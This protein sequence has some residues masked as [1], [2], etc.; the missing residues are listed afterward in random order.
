MYV[1]VAT[2][3]ILIYSASSSFEKEGVI[4]IGTLFILFGYLR[5]IG[6]AFFTFA[7]K[8]GEIVRQDSAVRAAE[9]INEEYE[10]LKI[11]K[12]K[13]LP[14]NWQKVEVKN[15]N[16]T[17]KENKSSKANFKSNDIHNA[18]FRFSR[19]DKIAFIGESGS[20]K[21]TVLSLLRG[22][23]FP[24]SGKVFCDGKKLES[25]IRHLN[26][27]ILL[28]P[29]DPEL[30]NATVKENI[31]MGERVGE[32]KI[33]KAM[34]VA[35]FSEVVTRLKKGLKTNV[36][37][38]GVS[39]SGGEKQRLALSR[40]LLVADK[41]DIILLDEPTSSVDSKNELAIYQKIFEE[42]KNK[43]II[44]SIH[45][46]HLLPKFDYIYQFKKGEIVLEGTFEKLLKD[47][48]FKEMWDDYNRREG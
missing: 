2:A 42:F 21:S 15:L 23:H 30:F 22:L 14:K 13:Y 26:E 39:L 12:E 34:Q 29:Q 3:G 33:K 11:K 28:I 20:G 46:L 32:E 35:K 44:S 18:S 7:W 45:R 47:K 5:R 8:Y 41:F 9:V 4:V 19:G 27:H 1:S 43:T 48:N 37:E 16:F 6:Q 31:T 25:G 36:M 10:K 40:G 24:E 38:K 17:Y